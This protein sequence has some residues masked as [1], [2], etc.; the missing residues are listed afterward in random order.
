MRWG[1]Q[2]DPL[3]LYAKH[4]KLFAKCRRP[5]CEN[6][7]ELHVPLLFLVFERETTLGEIGARFRCGKCQLRGARIETQ[8]VGPT[9]DVR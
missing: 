3:Q 2:G 6:R 8:Y 4:Y 9:H 7:Q 1:S 5:Y